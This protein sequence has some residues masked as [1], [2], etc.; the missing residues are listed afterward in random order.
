[1]SSPAASAPLSP[2]LSLNYPMSLAVYEKYE[3]A[4]KVMDHLSDKAFP[5]Q[6][7]QIVGTDLKQVE[8]ITGRLTWGKVAM[9]GIVSGIWL[10]LFVGLIFALFTDEKMWSVMLSTAAFGAVFGLVWALIGYAFSGGRRDF[11]SISAVIA[12]RYEILVEHKH[13][14]QAR[15][16]L[17]A[18]P[19]APAAFTG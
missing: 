9:A 7:C 17:G 19:D 13:I 6:N 18:M 14:E 16:I 1:M 8:R 4:Q 11:T 12:T 2:H 3:Q 15:Q 5:V 10:G